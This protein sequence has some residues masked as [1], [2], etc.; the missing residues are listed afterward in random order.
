MADKQATVEFLV[1][2]E[3]P[4]ARKVAGGVWNG[5][6]RAALNGG[7]AKTTAQWSSLQGTRFGE[8]VED[9]GVRIFVIEQT[10]PDAV[11]H[12]EAAGSP[13]LYG[14]IVAVPEPPSFLAGPLL[15]QGMGRL[16]A[17]GVEPGAVEPA[18][19][20]DAPEECSLYARRLLGRLQK[21]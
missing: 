19:L 1:D 14:L 7:Y 15:E 20:P 5:L 4:L 12:V 13:A 16:A 18:L 10:F 11:D 21:V 2:Y 8:R 3:S 6:S 9:P 17:G